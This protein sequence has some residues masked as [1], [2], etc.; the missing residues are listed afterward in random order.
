[1]F[2]IFLQS[3]LVWN[4]GIL[5]CSVCETGFR[6]TVGFHRTSLGVPEKQWNK[7]ITI[8]MYLKK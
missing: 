1:M 3:M 5:M 4:N 2:L 8:L 6:G 7:Y